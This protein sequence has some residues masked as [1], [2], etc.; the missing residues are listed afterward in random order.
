MIARLFDW[1]VLRGFAAVVILSLLSDL[2]ILV[3]R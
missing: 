3:A 1:F 2:A